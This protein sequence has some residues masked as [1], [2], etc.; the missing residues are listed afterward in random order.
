MSNWQGLWF[1]CQFYKAVIRIDL[2]DP[3]AS[4]LWFCCSQEWCNFLKSVCNGDSKKSCR[5]IVAVRKRWVCGKK[6]LIARAALNDAV[7]GDVAREEL[8][9]AAVAVVMGLACRAWPER[10]MMGQEINGAKKLRPS[11]PGSRFSRSL[12]VASTGLA[13]KFVLFVILERFAW[14]DALDFRGDKRRFS[15][16]FK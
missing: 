6:P 4:L 8:L 5:E 3:L 1:S 9:R 2:I 13:I 7:I 12:Q 15:C 14:A 10:A 11:L 16:S